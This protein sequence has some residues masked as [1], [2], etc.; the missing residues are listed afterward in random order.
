[1]RRRPNFS[2][3]VLVVVLL[4][5]LAF[6][7]SF[8]RPLV[9]A[10][11]SNPIANYAGDY[12]KQAAAEQIDWH[13]AD[14]T[15]FAEARRLDRPVLLFI[16]V[17]WSQ[18][19]RDLDQDVLSNADVQN[20]LSQN[21]VCI[22][23]DGSEA[24]AWLSAYLPISRVALGLRPRFQIWA[25][26]PD[27]KLITTINR[28]L[29]TTRLG[30]ANFLNELVRAHDFYTQLRQIGA[31]SDVDK[32]QH[33]DVS[34]MQTG[35]PVPLVDFNAMIQA[36]RAS[37][38]TRY[39]GFPNNGFQDLRPLAWKFLAQTGNDKL[40]HDTL[41]PALRSPAVDVLDGGFF[42]SARSLDRT[43]M[44]FD[45]VAIINA[46]M[47]SVLSLAHPYL[48]D[49]NDQAL[50]DYV[51]RST[52]A[53]LTGEFRTSS[54]FIN[55]ARI[56]DEQD[57]G[58]S[59]RSSIT[60]KRMRDTMSADDR[61]WS[62][63]HLGLLVESNPQMIP[64]L[65][66]NQSITKVDS[67][68]TELLKNAPAP[69]FSTHVFMDVNATVAA[70][71]MEC[72][73]TTGDAQ[74]IKLGSDLFTQI[75]AE[76]VGD[77]VPHDLEVSGR[78]SP[79]LFDYLAYA[80]A[81][82]EDYLTSGRVPSLEN[83][84]A[85]LQRGLKTYAGPT[86]GVFRVGL[87][88]SSDLLPSATANPQVVDDIGESASAKAVRL[89]TS[90][91][92]LYLGS[93]DQAQVGASLIRSAYA[94]QLLLSQP[95]AS[96]GTSAVSFA[97]ATLALDDD[98]FAI[99]VGPDALNL[100]NQLNSARPTRFVAPAFGPARSDLSSMKPGIYVIKKGVTSGP[101]TIDEAKSLLPMTLT[102]NQ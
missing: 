34:A 102:S 52:V 96:L 72:G 60:P 42:Y 81:A 24:P 43:Q 33:T 21:F 67:L 5:L 76:R 58:R 36:V 48:R 31:R 66:S 71:L 26:E 28:R 29:P 86:P 87:P 100:S 89:C 97:C 65:A 19:G 91:G 95:V 85:V 69:T 20:Y 94:C 56:G 25:L 7:V 92:R 88:P 68:R 41:M 23:I 62:R 9:P 75:D 35:S 64:Y 77:T 57:D 13:P 11:P 10:P 78:S 70:R 44:E 54:G 27:G 45:K 40:L 39:G 83:G 84:V 80:D 4:V 8:I 18:A 16:G 6:L 99:A 61:D 101:F 50:C 30:Q 93:Q 90:Y 73:R 51:M 32:E 63:T 14:A 82:L 12:L 46:E 15:A 22:R 17:A 38:D 53:S 47:A 49:P 2:V 59:L 74:L 55:T 37:A 79:A 3:L 98:E 1:M